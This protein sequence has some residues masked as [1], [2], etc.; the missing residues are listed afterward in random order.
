MTFDESKV[1]RDGGGKFA[2]K[3]GSAPEVSLSSRRKV[4]LPTPANTHPRLAQATVE[5]GTAE[6]LSGNVSRT[7]VFCDGV[8]AGHVYAFPITPTRSVGRG[9]RLRQDLKERTAYVH[10][11][12]DS[13]TLYGARASRFAKRSTAIHES[14]NAAIEN[15]EF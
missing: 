2:E 15:G 10:S 7:P 3:A 11:F 13:P 8:A 6:K 9:G 12:S 5:V 14:L 1:E 4:T